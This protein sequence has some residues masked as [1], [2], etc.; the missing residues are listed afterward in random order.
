ML[1]DLDAL[2]AG[3]GN[4]AI[5]PDNPGNI[6]IPDALTGYQKPSNGKA[7]EA[8]IPTIPI[9]PVENARVGGEGLEIHRISP[10]AIAEKRYAR[11]TSGALV[12]GLRVGWPDALACVALGKPRTGHRVHRLPALR[13]VCRQ[14]GRNPAPLL[15]AL[16]PW[17]SGL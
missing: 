3:S 5:I 6:P 11:R 4:P 13:I 12:A 7:C 8:T 1:L 2:M 14:R 15:L 17:L 10:A 16:Q 9:I